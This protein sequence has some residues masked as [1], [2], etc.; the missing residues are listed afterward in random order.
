VTFLD[1]PKQC[2]VAFC[3]SINII[4]HVSEVTEFTNKIDTIK[5]G[6][7]YGE[8]GVLEV[9]CANLHTENGVDGKQSE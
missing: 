7:S 2:K 6:I 9:E 1:F 4:Q 5:I 8:M 3:T